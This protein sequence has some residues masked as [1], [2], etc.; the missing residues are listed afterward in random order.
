MGGTGVAAVGHGSSTGLSAQSESG[1]AAYFVGPVHVAGNLSKSSGSFLI[2]HPIDPANK[3]LRHSFIESPDM[4]NV[5]DGVVTL[6][7]KGEAW[8]ELPSYF[9][10]LNKDYRYQLTNIGA[11]AITYV[12]EKIKNNRFK[13]A[14][15]R[16][17]MEVSWQVTG[18]RQ[19]IYAQDNPI[20]VEEDKAEADQG[21]YLYSRDPKA[22]R[23]GP[24]L[25]A[26]EP[27]P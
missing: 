8:V 2:D 16:P 24:N 17:A 10:A 26:L 21:K 23:I 7:K 9:S 27:Q 20:V 11:P 13:I 19:D 25:L 12:A 5:Y 18:I 6:D 14:G 1:W 3:Y 15:G 22:E 4:K